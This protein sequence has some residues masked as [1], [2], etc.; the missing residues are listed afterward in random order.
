MKSDKRNDPK[1]Q[2]EAWEGQRIEAKFEKAD[3]VVPPL[4]SSPLCPYDKTPLLPDQLNCPACGSRVSQE[5]ISKA[6]PEA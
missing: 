3:P 4:R 6:L 5:S 1:E 2:K